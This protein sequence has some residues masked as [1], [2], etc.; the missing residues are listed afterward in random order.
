MYYKLLT[1]CFILTLVYINKD[2][3]HS[4]VDPDG[5]PI[6]CGGHKGDRFKLTWIY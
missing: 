4:N 2:F 5:Q 6:V 3:D 1:T